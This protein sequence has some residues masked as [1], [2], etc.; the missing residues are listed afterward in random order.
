MNPICR[1]LEWDSAFFGAK[2]ARIETTSITPEEMA[3]ALRWCKDAGTECLYYLADAGSE[4]PAE[5]N[6]FL[7]VDVRVTLGREVPRGSTSPPSIRPAVERDLRK[8]KAIARI[9]HRDSRFYADPNFPDDRCD[10]LYEAWIENSFNGFADAV[11]VTEGAAG[12]ITC[13]REGSIGLVG[14]GPE[15]QGKGLGRQLIEGAL[16]WFD[17]ESVRR[18][19]VVTQ[20]R[21]EGARRFYERCGFKTLREQRWYHRWFLR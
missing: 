19:K 8:L 17:R 12:Y 10:Q 15:A 20:G 7:F 3:E 9:N 18:V 21:N 11:L 4:G 13:H 2:I 16:A 5:E 1:P 6:G 14:V